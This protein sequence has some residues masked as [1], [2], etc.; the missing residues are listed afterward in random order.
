MRRLRRAVCAVCH[1]LLTDRTLRLHALLRAAKS[2]A[3]QRPTKYTS[4]C[5]GAPIRHAVARRR[6]GVLGCGMDRKMVEQ[7]LLQAEEAVLSGES[8]IVRQKQIIQE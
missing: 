8:H 5:G 3:G 7:H 2:A 1:S 4:A 6:E